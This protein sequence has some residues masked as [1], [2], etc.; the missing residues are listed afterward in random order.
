MAL[1]LVQYSVWYSRF[2]VRMMRV[3]EK[4]RD[5]PKKYDASSGAGAVRSKAGVSRTYTQR[6]C[7]AKQNSGGRAAPGANFSALPDL[8]EP[9]AETKKRFRAVMEP[10]LHEAKRVAGYS[11]EYAANY[12]IIYDDE[13]AVGEYPADSK[14][15]PSECDEIA[16]AGLQVNPRDA[17]RGS[18]P[19]PPNLKRIGPDDATASLREWA[20]MPARV[21]DEG[22]I[23]GPTQRAVFDRVTEW[24]LMVRAAQSFGPVPP[25][26]RMVLLGTAGTGKTQAP[27]RIVRAAREIFASGDSVFVSAHT[28]VAAS[29]VGCGARTLASF[30]KT[31]GESG[32]KPADEETLRSLHRLFARCVLLI[33]DAISMVGAQ[34][35][36]A[37]SIRSG[38]AM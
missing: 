35:F 3:G 38:E 2:P 10:S 13:L 6:V 8:A 20:A 7:A 23:L 26:L 29:N 11:G 25:P 34:Q 30:F 36:A 15:A 22:A 32:R 19:L 12:L 33:T 1:H 18:D 5:A 28:G 17:L 24:A 37:V 27:R 14:E 16:A 21:A 31:M 9:L 4:E